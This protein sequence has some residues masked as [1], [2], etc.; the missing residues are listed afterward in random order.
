MLYHG[1]LTSIFREGNL[2]SLLD[3]SDPETFLIAGMLL[4]PL[5]VETLIRKVA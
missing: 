5:Q 2:N 1:S 3:S 4:Y